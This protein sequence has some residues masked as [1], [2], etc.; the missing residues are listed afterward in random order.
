MGARSSPTCPIVSALT[1]SIALAG[2]H[3]HAQALVDDSKAETRRSQSD[4]SPGFQPRMDSVAEA[5]TSRHA[6]KERSGRAKTASAARSHVSYAAI[7]QRTSGR[8]SGGNASQASR[9][10]TGAGIRSGGCA[11][12]IDGAPPVNS[13]AAAVG[14]KCESEISVPRWSTRIFR[15]KCRH[16]AGSASGPASR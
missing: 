13:K 4:W 6:P 8:N 3:L 10:S 16:A 2:D 5:I 15:G 9:P 12:T 14:Q 11:S 7:S 1:R